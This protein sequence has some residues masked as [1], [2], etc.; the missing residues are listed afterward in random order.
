VTNV[1]DLGEFGLIDRLTRVLGTPKGGDLI[2][3]IGDDAAVWRVGDEFVIATTDTMVEGVHFEIGRAPWADIGWKALATNVSDIGA[4]GGTPT[5]ALVT[6]AVP[7]NTAADDVELIYAG[8]AEC[9]R[10]Y[11]VTIVGG[12][13]VRSPLMTITVALIGR[14]ERRDDEPLLLRR[15]GARIGDIIAVTG[16]L[17]DSAA[18]LRRLTKDGPSEDPLVKRHLL[19]HPPLSAGRIAVVTG[20]TCGIDVS[21]GLLQDV[22]HICEQSHAGAV[23]RAKD[24]PLSSDLRAAYPD[25]SLQLAC[26]GGEDYELVLV[27]DRDLLD[28]VAG[29]MG[30]VQLTAI[31]EIV[32]DQSHSVKLLDDAGNEITFDRPGWDAFR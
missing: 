16:T 30:L 13:T 21:D 12:D 2:V 26:T 11:G 23:L 29:S 31:G 4:M 24:I 32:R 20:V 10:E 7:P 9:A 18:G 27:G 17:G 3:G 8:L 14:A 6:L 19:P 5:F 1:S 28:A 25:D 15:D 22:S